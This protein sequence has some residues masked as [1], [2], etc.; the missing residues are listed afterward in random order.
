MKGFIVV[1]GAAFLERNAPL[2]V[3]RAQYPLFWQDTF[4]S[5]VKDPYLS[6]RPDTLRLTSVVCS[7]CASMKPGLEGLGIRQQRFFSL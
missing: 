7:A 5:P 2:H 4:L 6:T 3:E 1:W